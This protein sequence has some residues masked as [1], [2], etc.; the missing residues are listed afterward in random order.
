MP[1]TNEP[2]QRRALVP[3]VKSFLS[4]GEVIEL[5]TEGIA[6]GG[7]AVAR[8]K[9]FVIFIPMAAPGER[10]RVRI[11]EVKKNF[12]RA[13]IEQILVASPSR[14]E[15]ACQY[16]G[17]CGGCQLQHIAGSAQLEA[18]AKFVQDA[19]NRI[20][21]IKWPH[22]VQVHS[23]AEFGYRCR[24][25]VKLEPTGDTSGRIRI[26]FNRAGSRSVC[27]VDKCPILMPE[28]N[29]ALA[30][31]RKTISICS[32]VQK[33]RQ[34]EMAAGDAGVAFEPAL[35]G[36]PSGTV[37]RKVAGA[38]YRF[39]PAT[40]FQVNSLLIEDLILTAVG[41]ESGQLAIDLY[42]GVGLFTVQLAR[43][44]DQVIGVESEPR[45]AELALENFS[46]NCIS[47]VKFHTGRATAWLKERAAHQAGD[48]PD[49]LLL[50]PPRGGAARDIEYIV[51]IKPARV[52][53]VSCNPTTMARDLRKLLDSGY[54]LTEV[55]AFD[56]FP[57]TY[58][59]ETVAKLRIVISS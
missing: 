59:V 50:D 47:N 32:D 56:M 44:F 17:Q 30:Q 38:I 45:A 2:Q 4:V 42:A 18:K 33:L 35:P 8:Y 27:D 53:Y 23:A 15:P 3:K 24:A 31:L 34:I 26:G 7:D 39:S 14:R 52:V 57:Q 21:R 28:L 25:Q 6:F 37:E 43:R 58:H 49:L 41:S 19:L 36:L 16:F 54:E 51:A 5:T 40:F 10:L 22:P 48:T 11:T 20:G 1:T 29:A 12:A 9:K 46:A 13:S 55:T